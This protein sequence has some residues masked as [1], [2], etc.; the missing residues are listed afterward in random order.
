MG[1]RGKALL[2]VSAIILLLSFSFLW[3]GVSEHNKTIG[4]LIGK[5]EEDINITVDQIRDR[6]IHDYEKRLQ[7]FLQIQP[8]IIKA[9]GDRDRERLY[10]LTLPV[11]NILQKENFLKIHLDFPMIFLRRSYDNS[12][13]LVA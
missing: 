4:L 11:F 1:Y 8:D 10:E 2:I 13:L 7:T 6:T 12:L 3:Y 9:F 5:T